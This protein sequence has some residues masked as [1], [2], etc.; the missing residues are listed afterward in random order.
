MC[1]ASRDLKFPSRRSSKRIEMLIGKE[2]SEARDLLRHIRNGIAHGNA[3]VFCRDGEY[4]FEII[5][6]NLNRGLHTAYILFPVDYLMSIYNIYW[7]IQK[8]I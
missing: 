4:Y 2:S 1:L 5:D 3:T 6:F 8:E 7:S